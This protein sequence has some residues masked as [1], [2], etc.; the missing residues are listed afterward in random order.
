[1]NNKALA[2]GALA[3]AV[4]FS[5]SACGDSG[6]DGGA[7]S[8]TTTS[9][10]SGSATGE[11]TSADHNQADVM[12]SEMMI[13]HHAQAIEMSDMLLAKDGIPEPVRSLAEEIKAAQQPEVEQFEVWLEEWGMPMPGSDG[14]GTGGHHMDEM[15]HMDGMMT[16]QDMEALS[17]AQGTDAA[18]LFLDQMIVHHE[19]AIEM[20]QD[21]TENGQFPETVE[22]ARTIADTQQ[23]EI[24]TMRQLSTTL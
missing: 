1:M 2:A 9:V 20:A 21:E 13:P 24:D 6:S 17:E 14:A 16:A 15:P 5:V 10:I 11:A 19:G 12:F 7:T 8:A 4:A 3:L 23:N 22:L 18:R